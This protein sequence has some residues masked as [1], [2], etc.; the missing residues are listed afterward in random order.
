M[1]ARRFPPPWTVIEKDSCFVVKD[2]TGRA[3]GWFCFHDDPVPRGP[4]R[5]MTRDDA[6]RMAASFAGLPE[7]LGKQTNET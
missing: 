3:M 7:L 4:I 2:D 5:V 6:L 1:T